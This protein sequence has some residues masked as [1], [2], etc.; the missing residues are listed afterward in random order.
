MWSFF[1]GARPDLAAQPPPVCASHAAGGGRRL[2]AVEHRSRRLRL[3]PHQRHGGEDRHA[4][5]RSHHPP[6]CDHRPVCGP[7]PAPDVHT[8]E[9]TLRTSGRSYCRQ[10]PSNPSVRVAFDAGCLSSPR[11]DSI[12]MLATGTVWSTHLLTLVVSKEM[13]S[14]DGR[15]QTLYKVTQVINP[16]DATFFF[17]FNPVSTN[18][19]HDMFVNITSVCRVNGFL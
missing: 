8:V 12:Q 13:R 5:E 11:L 18:L 1:D 15:K 6:V 2:G 14:T 3:L 9:N 10:A 7:H 4:G 19:H 17:F 16:R